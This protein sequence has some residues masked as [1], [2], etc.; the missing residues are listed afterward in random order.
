MTKM[1]DMI[2]KKIGR[3]TVIERGPNNAQGKAHWKCLCDCGKIVLVSG[4]NLRNGKTQSCGCLQ[5]DRT[6]EASRI[7]II[8]QTIGNFTVLEY[9]QKQFEDKGRSKWKCKCNLCGNEE[10]YLTTDNMKIQYSCGCSINSK[11]EAKIK[12]ILKEN[13]IEYIQEKRFNDCVFNTKKIARFD[14]YLPQ[15]NCL[16]EYD[17]I[18]HFQQGKGIYDNEEKFKLTKQHDEIKNNY[19]KEKGIFLIRIPY[20]HYNNIILKDLLPLTSKFL[21]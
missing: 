17:G 4:T 2:G 9:C 7:N 20:T 18:Q 16:I 1:I 13:N 10:V 21:I 11:G 3:L 5:R 12:K 15:E 14:F 19:C 6:S 8:G